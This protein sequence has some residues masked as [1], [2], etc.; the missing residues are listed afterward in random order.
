ME[1]MERR[2]ELR[3]AGRE[4]DAD[5]VERLAQAVRQEEK[6]LVEDLSAAFD[7]AL[8]TEG[9]G[10][11]TSDSDVARSIHQSLGQ[12]RYLRRFLDEADAI[13]DDL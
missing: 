1:I 7:R 4:K 8:S 5:R 9:Q 3:D 10:T 11:L 12:L 6:R 2:E 13:L